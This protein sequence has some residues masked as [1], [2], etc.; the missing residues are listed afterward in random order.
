MITTNL[1]YR[2]RRNNLK[3]KSKICFEDKKRNINEEWLMRNKNVECNF[4]QMER[5]NKFLMLIRIKLNK[6]EIKIDN[7][8]SKNKMNFKSSNVKRTIK[9]MKIFKE[10]LY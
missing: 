9:K 6:N 8:D 5:T 1:N 4:M 2:R 10:Q 3:N 7:M